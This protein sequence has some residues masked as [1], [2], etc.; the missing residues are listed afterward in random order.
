MFMSR[1]LVLP[2]G[3]R[4]LEE[5]VFRSSQEARGRMG[6]WRRAPSGPQRLQTGLSVPNALHRSCRSVLASAIASQRAERSTRRGWPGRGG[7]TSA[8]WSRR[9]RS[10][11][12]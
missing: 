12:R 8:S 10:C 1:Y 5:E 9:H 6:R 3:S 4:W 2:L 11:R 7:A